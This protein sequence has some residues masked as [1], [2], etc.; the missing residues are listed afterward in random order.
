[1]CRS[2]LS[3]SPSCVRVADGADAAAP[4]VAGD[5][6]VVNAEHVHRVL[7]DRQAIEIGVHD[8]VGDIAVDEQFAGRQAD[9]LVGGNAAVRAADP[10]EFRRLL[11]QQVL[12]EFRV[13]LANRRGPAGVVVE[14]IPRRE[15]GPLSVPEKGGR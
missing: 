7:D 15:H 14:E 12:E 3:I 9:D 5:D 13:A 8:D 4:V 11:G 1:M 6:H 2:Q 10:E